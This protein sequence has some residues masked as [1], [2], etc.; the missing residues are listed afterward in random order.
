MEC[1]EKILIQFP[2]FFD[3]KL[4][5]FVIPIVPSLQRMRKAPQRRK[6]SSIYFKRATL[7]GVDVCNNVQ[8]I[9]KV[10]C[11]SHNFPRG[12]IQLHFHRLI[13]SLALVRRKRKTHVAKFRFC[14]S[15]KQLKGCL[16]GEPLVFWERRG[17]NL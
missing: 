17:T 12:M 14:N 8:I 9:F 10:I 13:V 1:N 4:N 2:P 15:I 7:P 6:M 16:I 11:L 5:N 3:S